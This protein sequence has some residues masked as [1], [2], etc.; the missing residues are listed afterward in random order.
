MAQMVFLLVIG[1]SSG[2]SIES[3]MDERYRK[4]LMKAKEKVKFEGA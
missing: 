3:L 1:F 4:I 2:S